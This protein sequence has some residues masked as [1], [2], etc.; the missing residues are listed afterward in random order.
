[1]GENFQLDDTKQG[2]EI[3]KEKISSLLEQKYQLIFGVENTGGYERN[4]VNLLKTLSRS[5]KGIMVFKLN[6]R[7]VKHQIQSLMKRTVDDGVSAYGIAIY[8]SNHYE[9]FKQN[10]EN[11]TQQNQ[12][13]TD[14]QLLHSMIQALIKQRTMKLNQMEKLMYQSFPELLK[15]VK[16]SMPMWLL[17]LIEKYPSAQSIRK[18]KIEKLDSIKGITITK[19]QELKDM[20]EMSVASLEGNIIEKILS[21]YSKDIQNLIEEIDVFKDLLVSTYKGDKNVELLTSMSGIAEWSAV[22]YLIELGD[23]KRFENTDQLAAFYGVNPSFKQSGD[24]LFKVKMSKQGNARMRAV[25]Y[26]IAHNLTM[27]NPYF[28]SMYAKYKG[29]GKKHGTVMGILMH[30]VLRVLWGMLKSQTTFNQDT[31]LKNQ[32]RSQTKEIMLQN[33]NMKVRRYQKITLDAPISRANSKKRKTIIEPKSLENNEQTRSS[34]YSLMQ[35]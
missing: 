13:I 14:G 22:S 18:A 25:L 32:E 28:K 1:M 5:Q 16:N 17:R 9:M 21:R 6:Q 30:K 15:F 8:M 34:N 4:W 12:H 29:K 23:Y 3:L 19:A 10:W 31:D 35:T 27:H 24:G 7:A 11:S 2:Y 26:N 20:A 33:F